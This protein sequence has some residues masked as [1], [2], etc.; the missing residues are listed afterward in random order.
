M[1]WLGSGIT[2]GR[3]IFFART[4]WGGCFFIKLNLVSGCVCLCFFLVCS[5]VEQKHVCQNWVQIFQFRADVW[6]E[7]AFFVGGVTAHSEVCRLPSQSSPLTLS[8][9]IPG[10]KFVLV[11]T[12]V[13]ELSK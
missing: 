9:A 1:F 6:W 2:L 5:P 10:L 7:V 12:M 13:G 3:L 8:P 11:L 4:L